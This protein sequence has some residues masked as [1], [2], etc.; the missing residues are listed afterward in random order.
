MPIGVSCNDYSSNRCPKARSERGTVSS[1]SWIR[2][3]R[4]ALRLDVSLDRLERVVDVVQRVGDGQKA[5]CLLL[6]GTK[7]RDDGASVS[8]EL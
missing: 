7:E 3:S 6:M 2:S 1:A 8:H 4:S 5:Q